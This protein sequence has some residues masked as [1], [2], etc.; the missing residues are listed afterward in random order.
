MAVASVLRGVQAQSGP[1]AV[2]DR[3]IDIGIGYRYI[4]GHHVLFTSMASNAMLCRPSSLSLGFLLTNPSNN[5]RALCYNSSNYRSSLVN[6]LSTLG[7]RSHRPPDPRTTIL[8]SCLRRAKTDG[9]LTN[10][11]CSFGRN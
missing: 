3:I 5:P 8:I 1:K 9:V 2:I 10:S 11:C 4:M 6:S 7:V